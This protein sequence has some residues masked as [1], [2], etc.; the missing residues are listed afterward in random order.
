MFAT[1]LLLGESRSL[2]QM[3]REGGKETEKSG[4]SRNCSQG[5]S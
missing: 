2:D 1:L 5:V 3:K 4:E